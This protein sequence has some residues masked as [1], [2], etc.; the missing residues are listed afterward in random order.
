MKERMIHIYGA[1][2]FNSMP[3]TIREYAGTLEEFK[4]VLDS[5]LSLIPDCPILQGYISHNMDSKCNQSNCLM[6]WVRNLNLTNW[7]PESA[8]MSEDIIV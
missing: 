2:L 3:R 5:F 8:R 1:R 4:I 7:N 6:D